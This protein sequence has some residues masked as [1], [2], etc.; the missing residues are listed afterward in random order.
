[1]NL[2][3]RGVA[4]NAATYKGSQPGNLVDN[5][6]AERLIQ[7]KLNRC[8]FDC[9]QNLH[10][11]EVKSRWKKCHAGGIS[12]Y[13]RGSIDVR[14][15]MTKPVPCDGGADIDSDVTLVVMLIVTTWTSTVRQSQVSLTPNPSEKS[16][17]QNPTSKQFRR[18]MDVHQSRPLLHGAHPGHRPCTFQQHL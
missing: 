15:M 5:K 17:Q 18:A 12:C 6:N 9:D 8:V 2:S 7:Y 10:L 16:T 13:M 1:M 3:S 4:R 14:V 11:R